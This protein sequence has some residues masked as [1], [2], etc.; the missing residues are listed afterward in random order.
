MKKFL[1]S[2]KILI[3]DLKYTGPIQ[4]MSPRTKSDLESTTQKLLIH[5]FETMNNWVPTKKYLQIFFNQMFESIGTY[6]FN[7]FQM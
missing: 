7:T 3:L 5:Y 1:E 4:T 2:Q 6:R